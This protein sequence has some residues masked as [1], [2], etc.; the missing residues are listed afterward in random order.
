M[1]S[2]TR[3][4]KPFWHS[5]GVE[6]SAML[7]AQIKQNQPGLLSPPYFCAVCTVFGAL[8]AAGFT[9]AFR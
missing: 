9:C 1:D 6:H 8:A 2:S 7:P 5:T 3:K 4:H